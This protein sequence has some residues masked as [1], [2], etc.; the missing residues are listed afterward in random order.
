MEHCK[1][2]IVNKSKNPLPGYMTQGAAGM[3]LYADLDGE[4]T[5]Q[6]MEIRS[7]PTGIHIQLP[8]GVEAQ[9]R[10]RSGLSSKYGITLINGIGTIDSDYR[11]EIKVPLINLGAQPYRI[12][13]GERICQ[14]VVKRYIVATL[15][16]VEELEDTTRGHGGFGHSGKR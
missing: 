15:E 7:I 10:A 6:P 4:V 14:M 5:L 9:I 2:Q 1:V 3:D 16:M 8:E 12:Q 13:P 11:G